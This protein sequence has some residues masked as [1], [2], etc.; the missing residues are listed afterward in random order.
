MIFL[1]SDDELY[2]TFLDGD[3]A[4]LDTLVLRHRVRLIAYLSSMLHNAEDAEDMAM[5]AFAR[6]MVKKPRIA[7]GNF[8]A[9]LYQT[10]RHL[11]FRYLRKYRLEDIRIEDLDIPDHRTAETTVMEAE[12]SRILHSCLGKMESGVKEALWLIYF[13]DMSY[14][15]AAKIMHVTSKKIDNLLMK[16][17]RLLRAEL[18]KEGITDAG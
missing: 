2:Q 14:A 6:I 16:G 15:Q 9:Y 8:R 4:G 3:T 1:H 18:E 11:T 12:R 17:K 7:E 10:A 5:E 13:E